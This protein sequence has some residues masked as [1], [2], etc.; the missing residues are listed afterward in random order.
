MSVQNTHRDKDA[1]R[2]SH[3]IHIPYKHWKL[4]VFM[5][6]LFAAISFVEPGFANST[7]KSSQ[8]AMNKMGR[9]FT[10]YRYPIAAGGKCIDP[11]QGE[12]REIL[13][14]NGITYSGKPNEAELEAL[15]KGI[16][17]IE[18]L[19]GRPIPASWRT[20]YNFINGSGRWNQGATGIN[21]RRRPGDGKGTNVARL[22]HELGHKVGNSG[23]YD[24]FSKFPG[25]SKCR[26]TGYAGTKR[27]ECF[28]E[29]FAAYVTFPDL[30]QH[31]CPAAA[32]FMSQKLF[33]TS[34]DRLANCDPTTLMAGDGRPD[35]D[36]QFASQQ[37]QTPA[38][39]N[40][41]AQ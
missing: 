23:A 27:N 13:R 3:S 16:G 35:V 15:A 38:K 9:H 8:V 24:Q 21:V 32:A 7:A 1:E 6:A 10:M 41:A 31:K 19:L 26:I 14:R 18:R 4:S 20:K 22:M 11:I 39:K 17:Q 40:G 30:L 2:A 36:I 29:V 5:L 28:A 34:P 37:P 12:S 33:Q 25:A